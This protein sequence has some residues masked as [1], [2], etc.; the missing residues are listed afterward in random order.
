MKP[1]IPTVVACTFALAFASPSYAGNSCQV[2]SG[3]RT[4]A[5]VELYTSEGCSSCPPADKQLNHLQQQLSAD[6]VV[7]PLALHVTYWNYLGWQD[8]LSQKIFD[9]RQSAL[10]ASTKNNGGTGV[11]YTPQFFVS[12]EELRGWRNGLPQAIQKINAKPAPVV[13][14]L[15]SKTVGT[16]RIML[17]ASVKAADAVDKTKING[18]LY[19]AISEN[20]LVSQVGSGENRGATLKHDDVVRAWFGPIQLTN[21]NG[22]L[23]QTITVPS[24]WNRQHLQLIA[25]AQDQQ[26]GQILQALSTQQCTQT[27]G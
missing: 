20:G 12:G 24:A 7:V 6:A 23:Q 4:A 13:I 17:D 2:K 3:A 27:K 16:D 9:A 22:R 18:A 14:T 25:F 19:V 8:G 1:L 10:V 21:G 11:I 5:L 15:T 26:S